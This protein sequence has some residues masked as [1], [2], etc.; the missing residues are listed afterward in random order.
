MLRSLVGSEMCIRDRVST[1]ST[2]E[3]SCAMG[4][5]FGDLYICGLMIINALAVLH[6]QRFL[7]KYGL[8]SDQMDPMYDPTSIKAKMS[9]VIDGVR[10]VMRWPLV[11]VNAITMVYLFFLG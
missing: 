10:T 2:G 6:E 5:S 4:F 11:F 8:G 1:Q 3:L 7:V 9:K